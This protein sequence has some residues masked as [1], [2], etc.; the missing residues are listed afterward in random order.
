MEQIDLTK[1]DTAILYV[2]RMAEGYHPV[3]NVEVEENV[4]LDN[5]NVIRCMYFI[6]DVLEEVKRN[7]GVISGTKPKAKR[8]KQIDFP[9]EILKEYKYQEDKTISYLLKQLHQPVEEMNIKKVS[10]QTVTGWLKRSGF[11]TEEY[12]AEVEK[13]STV[14]TEKGKELGIYTETRRFSHNAYLAVI[15]NRN[16][17][18]Y[19][20]NHFEKIVHGEIVE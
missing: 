4:I 3:K 7:N 16:A 6:K 9:F 19:I 13:V 17:Q 1:L 20:V 18:E 15:Y 8:A 14:P 5:R 2:Q 11:L 10:P 12:S